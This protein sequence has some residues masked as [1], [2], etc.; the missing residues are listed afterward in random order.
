MSKVLLLQLASMFTSWDALFLCATHAT[1]TMATAMN[2]A[3][4]VLHMMEPVTKIMSDFCFISVY[5]KIQR[6]HQRDD[7]DIM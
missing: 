2:D 4:L 1:T 6:L 3:H 7:Q 5:S